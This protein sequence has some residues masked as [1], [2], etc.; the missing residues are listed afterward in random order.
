[1]LTADA[2]TQTMQF[3]LQAYLGPYH[4]SGDNP[5][6]PAGA[7]TEQLTGLVPKHTRLLHQM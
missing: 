2:C 3:V 4:V 5:Q 6:P 1:M 7:N